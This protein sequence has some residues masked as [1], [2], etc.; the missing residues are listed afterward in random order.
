MV[1]FSRLFFKS[2]F[3][4]LTAATSP[5]FQQHVH[6]AKLRVSFFVRTSLFKRLNLIIQ[7]FWYSCYLFFS[8]LSLRYWSRRLAFKRL[9]YF[10]SLIGV[11][12]RAFCGMFYSLPFDFFNAHYIQCFVQLIIMLSSKG[13]SIL[14]HFLVLAPL[15]A[16]VAF[17]FPLHAICGAFFGFWKFILLQM[18]WLFL[19]SLQF[20]LMSTYALFVVCFYNSPFNLF[21]AYH[22]LT[23]CTA[24]ILCLLRRCLSSNNSSVSGFWCLY[25]VL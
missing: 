21:N 23:F 18:T 3:S 13:W 17:K 8:C 19:I 5:I 24:A 11:H 2:E 7:S 4:L 9:H 1:H 14:I 16:D 22:F 10:W 15:A 25:W 12:L 6:L 20:M